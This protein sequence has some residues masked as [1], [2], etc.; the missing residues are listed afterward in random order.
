VVVITI[1]TKRG[2]MMKRTGSTVMTKASLVNWCA[3]PTPRTLVIPAKSHVLE[4]ALWLKKEGYR[5]STIRRYA[6]IIRVL[7]KRA[8]GL[9]IRFSVS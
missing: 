3:N 8:N 1:K 6:K 7:S 2:L 4:F 9:N 5:E